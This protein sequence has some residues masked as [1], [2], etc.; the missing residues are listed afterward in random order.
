MEARRTNPKRSCVTRSM[1]ASLNERKL[2][3]ILQKPKRERSKRAR[4]SSSFTRRKTKKRRKSLSTVNEIKIELSELSEEVLMAILEH[5]PAPGLVNMSK[6][7]WLFNRLCHTDSLWKHRCK[8]DFNLQTKWAEFSYLYLY[9]MF[10]KANTLRDDQNFFKPVSQLKTSVIVWYLTNPIPPCHVVG[11]LTASQVKSIWGVTEDELEEMY[12]DDAED[13]PEIFP[14]CH[15]EWGRLYQV[16]LKKHGGVIPMQNYVLKRCY[17]NRQALEEHY[18]LSLHASRRQ[19]WYQYLED[20]DVGNREALKALTEH[21]PKV[22]YIYMLH[23]ITAMYIDGNLKGGFQT[24]KAYAEFCALFKS[25]MEE[26]SIKLW[27]P[28]LGQIMAQDY[29]DAL[30]YVNKSLACEAEERELDVEA[31]MKKACPFIEKLHEVWLWQNQHGT[32]YRKEHRSSMIVRRFDR[33]R[34]YLE[35]GRVEDFTKLRMYFERREVLSHWLKDNLWLLSVL[36]DAVLR[37]L[38]PPML[39]PEYTFPVLGTDP[40][41]C[42]VQRFVE[43]GLF[44]DFNKVRM[45]LSELASL[46]IHALFKKSQN[47]ERRV[48]KDTFLHTDRYLLNDVRRQHRLQPAIMAASLH[49]QQQM[50]YPPHNAYYQCAPHQFR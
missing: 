28:R 19:K 8:I 1:T 43:T 23:Q 27:P 33:Y 47:L 50:F 15:Y 22:T 20:R 44:S 9:E 41:A 7:C 11:H 17:R 46:Q 21:M 6:T 37:S 25:W 31:F 13:R 30:D 3:E 36:G 49:P 4:T 34:K 32:A 29:R 18:K 40:V 10:F 35:A 48:M 24:V 42:L 14:L 38:R 2:V 16:F 39:T 26:K 45:K 5:V 12:F